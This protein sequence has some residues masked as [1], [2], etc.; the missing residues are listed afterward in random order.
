[1][2]AQTRI[3]DQRQRVELLGPLQRSEGLLGPGGHP[4]TYA[5]PVIGRRIVRVELDGS[6]EFPFGAGPVPLIRRKNPCQRGVSLSQGVVDLQCLRGR[7]LGLW[8]TLSRRLQLMAGEDPVAVGQADVGQSV[9]GVLLNRL[10]E[11]VDGA[12]QRL[13]GP[14]API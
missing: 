12:L 7:S 9:T 4:Q 5:I 13:L 6:L 8:H 2:L 14:S 1:M 10:L 11:V 3:Y